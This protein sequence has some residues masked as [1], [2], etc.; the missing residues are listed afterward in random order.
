MAQF[1][2]NVPNSIEDLVSEKN[3]DDI[4][5]NFKNFFDLNPANITINN[6]Y[7]FN[8]AL[9]ILDN[10]TLEQFTKGLNEIVQ[11]EIDLDFLSNKN[12][13]NFSLNN[14]LFLTN[15]SSF[16]HSEYILL[17]N[18]KKEG[19]ISIPKYD[20]SSNEILDTGMNVRIYKKEDGKKE[21]NIKCIVNYEKFAYNIIHNLMEK[22]NFKKSKE[23]LE[24]L[25]INMENELINIYN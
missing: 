2:K 24:K 14:I 12:S 23:I 18:F 25:K 4:I 15:K 16:N 1:K 6:P 17:N 3:Q 19:Y 13:V 5:N 20:I 10:L 7:N 22:S 21:I 11:K 8:R 9:E